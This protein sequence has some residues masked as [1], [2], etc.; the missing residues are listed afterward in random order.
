MDPTW[1]PVLGP[2]LAIWP[3]FAVPGMPSSQNDS[4]GP[5]KSPR[6]QSKPQFSPIFGGFGLHLGSPEITKIIEITEI[7]DITEINEITE[8][9]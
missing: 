9:H 7:T 2:I 6:D 5:P 4:Q 8:F 1:G 3:L